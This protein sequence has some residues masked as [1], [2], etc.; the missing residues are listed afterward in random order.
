MRKPKWAADR[1]VDSFESPGGFLLDSFKR[2]RSQEVVPVRSDLSLE[3][4]TPLPFRQTRF[5]LLCFFR[6][7]LSMIDSGWT[8]PS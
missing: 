1:R 4:I 3:K 6:Q 8:L 5:W 2:R 7:A